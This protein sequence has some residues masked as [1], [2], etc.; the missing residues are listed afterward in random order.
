MSAPEFSRPVRLK[1]ID[2]RPVTIAA[3]AEECAQLARRFDLRS[4]KDLSAELMLER[5]GD[6]VLADGHLAAH[7]VQSCAVS[8]EDLP[9][10]IEET[11][12][13]RFVPAGPEPEP[14][15]DE[16]IE[17]EFDSVDRDEI[18]YR[19]DGIDLGEAVAQS[20]ALAID[21]YAEGPDADAARSAAGLVSDDA[22]RGPLA[23][24][25]AGLKLKG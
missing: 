23:D 17:I 13:F 4:V 5:E 14:A 20:L 11:L 25:L 8:G 9:V 7:I 21:P 16:P 10:T 15:G 12:R 18:E 3:S 1:Q 19:G 2:A 22:P 6:D 24:A